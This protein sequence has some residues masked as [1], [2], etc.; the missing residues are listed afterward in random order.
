MISIYYICY[1]LINF[2]WVLKNGKGMILTENVLNDVIFI[3][4]YT[5]ILNF[6]D[7]NRSVADNFHKVIFDLFPQVHI[8]S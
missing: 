2:I 4:D 5:I 7:N 6:T 3:I 8:K 1:N